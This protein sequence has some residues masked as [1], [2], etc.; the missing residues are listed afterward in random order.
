MGTPGVGKSYSA[1][2]IGKA[3]K[4]CGF[5]TLGDMKEKKKPVKKSSIN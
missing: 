5:L 2:I 1:G 3:L 4:W